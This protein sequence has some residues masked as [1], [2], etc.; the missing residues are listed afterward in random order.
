MHYDVASPTETGTVTPAGTVEMLTGVVT[1]QAVAHANVSA[2]LAKDEW[3]RIFMVTGKLTAIT[4][5]TE[6]YH[7]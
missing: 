5:L 7:P 6:M 1:E 3:G 2:R 4:S